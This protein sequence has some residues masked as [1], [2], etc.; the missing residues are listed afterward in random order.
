MHALI[1]CHNVIM[2]HTLFSQKEIKY[3]MSQRLARIVTAS[4]SSQENRFLQ[5]DVVPIGFDFNGE[6]FYR[7]NEYSE[8]Y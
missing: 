3:L 7:R 8:V 6:F 4:I 2:P 5:L 1:L